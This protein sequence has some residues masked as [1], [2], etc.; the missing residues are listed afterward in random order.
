MA[1][2]HARGGRT[3]QVGA[4]RIGSAA[5]VRIAV[6]SVFS[7]PFFPVRFFRSVFSGPFFSGPFFP[8]RFFRSVFFRSVFSG[9]F[10]PDCCPARFGPGG[11]NDKRTFCK[12]RFS[13]LR[14]VGN[15]PDRTMIF[16]G[17]GRPE[18]RLYLHSGL[19]RLCCVPVV[20]LLCLCCASAVSLSCLCCASAAPL[21]CLCC[22]F[23]VSPP[24]F[25]CVFAVP[26][27]RLRRTSAVSLP[28]LC[29]VSA[30]PPP[31]RISSK[32]NVCVIGL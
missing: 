7:G 31:C 23:V 21:L 8:V 4:V 14:P 13:G 15:L 27:L 30:V 25:C 11:W 24:R 18:R 10:R 26:L 5:T 32:C 17:T 20:P 16:C 2:P 29:C 12:G 28:C 9:P 6:R 1:L 3:A 22:A 19:P